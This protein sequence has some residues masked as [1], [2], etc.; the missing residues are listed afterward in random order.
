MK[1]TSD[2]FTT[3]IVIQNT[4]EVH[5]KTVKVT[6]ILGDCYNQENAEI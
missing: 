1:K 2:E 3:G 4:Q 6:K 5:H